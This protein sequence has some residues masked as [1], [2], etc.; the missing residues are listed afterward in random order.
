MFKELKKALREF[1]KMSKLIWVLF[2]LLLSAC[3]SIEVVPGNVNDAGIAIP[4]GGE[5]DGG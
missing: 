2:G 1:V 4:D 5:V 3:G